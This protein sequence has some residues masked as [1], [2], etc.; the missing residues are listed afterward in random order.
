MKTFLK[1]S[2]SVFEGLEVEEQFVNTGQVQRLST[3]G[4]RIGRAT[5][6]RRKE[7]LLD[8]HVSATCARTVLFLVC[9]RHVCA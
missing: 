9:F 2:V 6:P 4:I 7:H 5:H 8:L 3:L 1:A